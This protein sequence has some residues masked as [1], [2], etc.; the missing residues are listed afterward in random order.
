MLISKSCPLFDIVNNS[1][2]ISSDESNDI[3][4][5]NDKLL[6]EI[7]NNDIINYIYLYSNLLKYQNL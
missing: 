6:I 2:S 1:S 4:I 5:I 3:N 7:N